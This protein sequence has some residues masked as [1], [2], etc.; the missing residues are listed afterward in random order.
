MCLTP[1]LGSASKFVLRKERGQCEDTSLNIHDTILLSIRT[2]ASH[3][4]QRPS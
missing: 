4:T 2:R 1:T 3:G